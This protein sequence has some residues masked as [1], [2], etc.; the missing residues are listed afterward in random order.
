MFI[1]FTKRCLDPFP[2][3]IVQQANL[4]EEINLDF[5]KSFLNDVTF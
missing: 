2:A 1:S 3:E 4:F 5:L